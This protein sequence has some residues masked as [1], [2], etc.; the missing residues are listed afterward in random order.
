MAE[1][2]T[3]DTSPERAELLIK[4]KE[5]DLEAGWLGKIFG[6]DKRASSN[7]AGLLIALLVV[8]GIA[9]L[10]FNSSIPAL[11]YWKIIS[12]LITLALGYLFGINKS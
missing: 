11:E 3:Y 7:I 6:A 2:T 8:S 9:L 12:P 10:F 5:M 4:T 1:K